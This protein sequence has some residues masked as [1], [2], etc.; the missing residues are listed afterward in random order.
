M[1]VDRVQSKWVILPHLIDW[2]SLPLVGREWLTS[3]SPALSGAEE[4]VALKPRADILFNFD[5]LTNNQPEIEILLARLDA[6][7]KAG[8]VAVPFWARAYQ[9]L[10]AAS[11]SGTTVTLKETSAWPWFHGEYVFIRRP[12]PSAHD[13]W[14]VNIVTNPISTTVLTLNSG[15]DRSYAAGSIV[16]PLLLGRLERAPVSVRTNRHLSVA[17]SVRSQESADG[18][19]E[20]GPEPEPS[21]SCADDLSSYEDDHGFSYAALGGG[22]GWNG[23]WRALFATY[24]RLMM[25]DDLSEYANQAWSD[26]AMDLGDGFTDDW[27]AYRTTHSDDWDAVFWFAADELSGVADEQQRRLVS[28]SRSGRVLEQHKT[29]SATY[30]DAKLKL[31]QVNGLPAIEITAAYWHDIQAELEQDVAVY[32]V[33]T[34]DAVGGCLVSL[35]SAEPRGTNIFRFFFGM[36]GSPTYFA[37]GLGNGTSYSIFFAALSPATVLAPSF[38]QFHTRLVDEVC[39]SRVGSVDMD[40]VEATGLTM[41]DGLKIGAAGYGRPTAPIDNNLYYEISGKFAE[42]IIT[43]DTSEA[44][45]DEIEAY[46]TAKYGV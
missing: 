46:F 30:S 33:A 4:R 35:G 9:T 31:A 43:P 11:A 29:P 24:D 7:T 34:L 42:I 25:T 41:V 19:S 16:C 39:F 13:D 17:I 36:G 27:R 10:T 18:T 12:G 40:P 23:D 32:A 3:V 37:L 6:A 21:P 15:L 28:I 1:T 44:T 22:T 38:A 5:V 14:E 2:S 26:A 45:R 20:L 8:Y